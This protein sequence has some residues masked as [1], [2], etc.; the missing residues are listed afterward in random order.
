MAYTNN[1]VHAYRETRVKTASQGRIIV[2]LYDEALRQIDEAV[3]L[4][5]TGTKQ[6]DRVN[7]SVVKAQ[8]IIT[9]LMVSLDM[10]Q[11]GDIARNLF[12]LYMFF[13]DRLMEGNVRKETKP[14][15][16]VRG[17]MA[18]LRDAWREI[19]N[20]ATP[21]PAVTTGVNIAG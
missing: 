2:M 17:L 11:G 6:L 9:E 12:R 19:E 4:L 1:S 3:G 18:S 20:V 16:E 14:L 15:I 10:E 13:N 5:D 21:S 7:N 8:D